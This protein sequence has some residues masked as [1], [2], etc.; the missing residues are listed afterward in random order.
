MGREQASA[1]SREH[2]GLQARQQRVG[3]TAEKKRYA[4]L[5]SISDDGDGAKIS[6][7]DVTCGDTNPEVWQVDIPYT[8]KIYSRKDIEMMALP[9]KE[10]AELGVDIIARLNAFLSLGKN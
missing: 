8:E 9:E 1:A 7:D 3:V 5:I 4:V 6:L 2:E 10:Y